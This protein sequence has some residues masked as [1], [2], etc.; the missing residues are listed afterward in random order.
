[1]SDKKNSPKLFSIRLPYLAG[2]HKGQYRWEELS[3][4][5][6]YGLNSK[7]AIV[8]AIESIRIKNFPIITPYEH[9]MSCVLMVPEGF[10]MYARKGG[11]YIF[12]MID[13]GGYCVVPALKK[14]DAKEYLFR[15][16][17]KVYDGRKIKARILKDS[18]YLGDECPFKLDCEER[19][20]RSL[21][22]CFPGKV[23][24]P[25]KPRSIS[26][27]ELRCEL[28]SAKLSNGSNRCPYCGWDSTYFKKGSPHTSIVGDE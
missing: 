18:P 13:G 4:F 20:S 1:M 26:V 14:D 24:L 11:F 28:C 22:L 3:P 6:V 27:P 9:T 25:D 7:N 21:E 15:Q 23:R 2:G 8:N 10:D 5:C 19:L 12:L 16:R 17:I